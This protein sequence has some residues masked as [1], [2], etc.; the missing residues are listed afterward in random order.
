RG[1]L[2]FVGSH[3]SQLRRGARR[4]A[5]GMHPCASAE[6]ARSHL[7]KTL[8]RFG[9]GGLRLVADELSDLSDLSMVRSEE[10]GSFVQ[11][12]PSQVMKGRFSQEGIKLRSKRRPGHRQPPGE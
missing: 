6:L 10:P 2:R 9:E 5:S 4:P 8:E 1:V 12:A 11:A 3:H 7:E